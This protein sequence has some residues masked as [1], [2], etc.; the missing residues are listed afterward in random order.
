ML[1]LRNNP[2]GYLEAAVQA[3]DMFLEDGTIVTIRGRDSTL[4]RER[5]EATGPGTYSGLSHG[6]A[7]NRFR[8]RQRDRRRFAARSRLAIVV[9]EQSFGKGTVRM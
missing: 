6:S 4:I 8:P 1:D 5:R 2:G 7:V 9:G 3:C